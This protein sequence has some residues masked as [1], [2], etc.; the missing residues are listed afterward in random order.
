MSD[1]ALAI[2]DAAER[3]IRDAGYSGFSYREIAKDVGVKASSVHYH[4]PGKE[5]L[6]AAVARRYTDR[7]VEAVAGERTIGSDPV[8][9]WRRVF[10]RA[11]LEDGRMCLCGALGTAIRD[12]PDE[13]VVEVRRFFKLGLETLVEAGLSREE[14]MRLFAT[15][16]GAMLMANTLDDASAFDL[17]TTTPA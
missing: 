7:F 16:E 10:R 3:R 11:L 17:A 9:A 5:L 13:V 15:L 1:I 2:L 6:A 12:L 14:A 4:F 8:E